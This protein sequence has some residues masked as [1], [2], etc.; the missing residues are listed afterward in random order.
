MI[1]V[2]VAKVSDLNYDS[3]LN[4]KVVTIGRESIGPL[5]SCLPLRTPPLAR[6][7]RINVAN[8]KPSN[9]K[10]MRYDARL[11]HSSRLLHSVRFISFAVTPCIWAFYVRVHHW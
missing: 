9:G 3:N 6:V 5:P 11:L 2:K 4:H 1:D 10:L 8:T 7:P